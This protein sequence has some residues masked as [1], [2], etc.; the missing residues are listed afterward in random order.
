MKSA[1]VKLSFLSIPAAVLLIWFLGCTTSAGSLFKTTVDGDKGLVSEEQ[2]PPEEEE[3]EEEEQPEEGEIVGVEILSDPSGAD[4]YVNN[5]Y[6]GET[7]LVIVDM[8]PGSYKLDLQKSGYY[9][10]S[11]WLEFEGGSMSYE[12]ALEQITGYLYVETEPP[13]AI[14]RVDGESVG[15][16]VSELPIG[17]YT[18]TVLAFGY[19]EHKSV[20]SIAE[21]QTTK[22]DVALEEADFRITEPR[23]SRS[24]LNPDNPGLLG[25]ALLTFQ[26]ST[27]GRGTLRILDETGEEVLTEELSPFTWWDQEFI[28]DG[29]SGRGTSLPDGA[30]TIRVEGRGDRDGRRDT[31]ERLITI[32]HSLTIAYR[33][34]WSG[35]SG[36][37]YAATT[38]TLPRS[39]FQI[40]SLL[41]GHFETGAELIYRAPLNLTARFGLGSDM[42]AGFGIGIILEDVPLVPL[43]FTGSFKYRAYRSAGA[44]AVNTALTGKAT[45]HTTTGTDVFTN[46]TGLSLGL[47]SQLKVGPLSLLIQP[48]IILSPWRVTYD[49]TADFMNPLGAYFWLYGRTGLLLDL[50]T[51]VTGI[52]AS[53]RSRPFSQ[54]FHIN[55]PFQGGFEIHLLLPNTQLY[56][57]FALAA[58][59]NSLYDWYLMGGGGLGYIY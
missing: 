57:S 9:A 15:Q 10:A 36:L 43:F 34:V 46:F 25:K 26:V 1:G 17:N 28:W 27:Y 38:E 2:K 12:V 14:V 11:G 19:E 33:S 42:E 40:A 45:F 41:M 7:P 49:P 21:K 55:L 53:V 3:E 18:V 59:I 20:V 58:E 22:V 29:R 39:S 50:G 44:I 30:Y 4:V 51:V 24:T 16:G 48:E 5:R 32:D 47:A 52:S 35:Q 8:E 6:M 54:G 23:L 31:I 37:L 56:A 13:D